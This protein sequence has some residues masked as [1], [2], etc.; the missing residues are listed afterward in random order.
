MVFQSL[1]IGMSCM[2]RHLSG[3]LEIKETKTRYELPATL[4]TG[5]YKMIK[6]HL[7]SENGDTFANTPF[8]LT[9]VLEEGKAEYVLRLSEESD[10]LFKVPASVVVYYILKGDVLEQFFRLQAPVDKAHVIISTAP[11]EEVERAS[12]YIT[13]YR[14]TTRVKSTSPEALYEE[15]SYAGMKMFLFGDVEGLDK[16]INIKNKTIKVDRK[17]F[18]RIRL[19]YRSSYDWKPADYIIELKTDQEL[20]SGKLYIY[21]DIFGYNV[22]IKVINMPDITGEGTVFVSKSW[23]VYHSWVL[24]KMSKAN[25]RTYVTGD[26][27]LKGNGSTRIVIEAKDISNFACSKGTIVHQA[28]DVV[29]IVVNVSDSETVSISFDYLDRVLEDIF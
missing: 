12:M 13:L 25:E 14:L 11:Y 15:T 20:P 5:T 16:D 27:K 18:N 29:E 3:Y 24:T 9:K 28:S 7:V 6:D 19:T 4:Q 8:G 10:V 17:D 1:K 23:Q 26:L 21:G 2:H 22:P